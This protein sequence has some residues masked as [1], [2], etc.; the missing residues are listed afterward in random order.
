MFIFRGHAMAITP[1]ILAIPGLLICHGSKDLF[2]SDESLEPAL[3]CL[4]QQPHITTSLLQGHDMDL[5]G[6]S[7]TNNA[8]SQFALRGSPEITTIFPA[9]PTALRGEG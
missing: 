2:V 3:A 8:L 9:I 7:S 4:Q 6:S 1:G 5:P